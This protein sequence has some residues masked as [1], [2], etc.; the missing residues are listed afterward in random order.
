MTKIMTILGTRPEIIRL[1]VIIPK[2]DRHAEHVFVHTGQNYDPRLNDIFF[3]ELGLRK[4]DY[5][6]Q[7][8]EHSPGAQIG[9]ILAKTEELLLKEKPDKLLILG[10]TN[11]GMSA[12]IAKRM[13]IPV[14]HMEAGN[15]CFDDKVPEE[16]NRRVI[17]H[18]S[19]FLMPYTYRSKEN[20]VAEGIERERIFVVGN[21]INE[22]LNHYAEPIAQ[23]KIKEKLGVQKNNF[24]LVTLHRAE[25]VDQ[26]KNLVAMMNAME[27]LHAEY[28]MPILCSF[29]PRTKSKV[30]QFGLDLKKTKITFLE[31][32]SFFDF[33]HLEK[34]A[35]CVVTDSGTVQEECCIFNVPSVTVREVTERPETIECGSNVLTGFNTEAICQTVALIKQSETKWQPP[36]E[37]LEKEV[38]TKILK[39]LLGY[40][41]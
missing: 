2:I 12:V 15:R 14:Y 4:P 13:Q 34:E 5:N 24:I 41:V 7:I 28:K 25:G 38:S 16:V 32:L 20:L 23:N 18:C 17:D 36:A 19:T 30:E 9:Q 40:N 27:Q 33:V 8:R 35:F 26:E 37:Y 39:I 29:H 10:D 3:E 22:V 1:S 6:F 31:P 21:P 11:S